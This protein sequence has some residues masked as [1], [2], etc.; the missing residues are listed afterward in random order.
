MRLTRF[1]WP[2]AGPQVP[3]AHHPRPSGGSYLQHDAALDEVVEGDLPPALSVKLPNEDVVKLVRE[4]VPCSGEGRV[5]PMPTP[6][7]SL[8]PP[9]RTQRGGPPV[10]PGGKHMARRQELHRVSALCP[11]PHGGAL[12]EGP[13]NHSFTPTPAL[14]SPCRDL[15]KS[16]YW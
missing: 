14:Q 15:E 2:S 4:P 6:E 7:P 13:R 11:R 16:P 1:N 3:T 5:N 8:T 9:Q 12:L 10:R